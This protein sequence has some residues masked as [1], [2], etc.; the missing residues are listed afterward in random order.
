MPNIYQVAMFN[1]EHYPDKV[2]VSD[3]CQ[4]L[5]FG[6][7]CA[8]AWALSAYAVNYIMGPV[9]MGTLF[10]PIRSLRCSVVI[11]DDG[12]DWSVPPESA[13]KVERLL[14]EGK[15]PV[16]YIEWPGIGHFPHSECP[17]QFTRDTLAALR[18]LSL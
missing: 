9:L 11:V 16:K 10:D 13:R 1:A 15:V 12:K 4:A 8:R 18:R 14:P 6:L 7:L 5:P 3:E 2:A 17:E